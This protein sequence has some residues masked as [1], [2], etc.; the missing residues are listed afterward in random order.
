MAIECMDLDLKDIGDFIGTESYHDVWGIKVT[1]GVKYIMD[2]GYS[3]FVTD[4]IA[5]LRA[6]KNLNNEEFLTIELKLNDGAGPDIIVTDGNKN[7]LY[8]NHYSWS[9]AMK[10]LKLFCVFENSKHVVMLS[11]EY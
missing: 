4:F 7:K 9:D 3:W 10:E 11:S 8:S 1:D 6:N 2:N 5:V